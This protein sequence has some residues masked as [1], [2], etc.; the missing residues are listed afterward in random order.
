MNLSFWVELQK[1]WRKV[2]SKEDKET[3]AKEAAEIAKARANA[4]I[5]K[6]YSK[7]VLDDLED[8]DEDDE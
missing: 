7:N 2:L 8:D 3:I 5:T 4:P 6:A 1:K